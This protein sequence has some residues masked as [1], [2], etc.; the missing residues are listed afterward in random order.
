[1]KVSAVRR[2]SDGRTDGLTGGILSFVCTAEEAAAAQHINLYLG[3][4]CFFSLR[5]SAWF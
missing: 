2:H 5:Q 4:I 3:A 1:M